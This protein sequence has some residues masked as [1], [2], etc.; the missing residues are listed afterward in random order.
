MSRQTLLFSATFP[1]EIK[2]LSERY[3]MHPETVRIDSAIRVKESVDHAFIEVASRQKV[4]LLLA[5][6]DRERPSKCLVFTAT[7]EMTGELARRLRTRN[8]E[9][10]S[11]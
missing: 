6:L 4:D 3:L 8:H 5:M 7:R 2:T 9:V 1:Q 11:L 10:V